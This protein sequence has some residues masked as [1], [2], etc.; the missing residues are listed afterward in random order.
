NWQ[1]GDRGIPNA[2][3][4]SVFTQT[5][6]LSFDQ[7]VLINKAEFS[8]LIRELALQAEEKLSIFRNEISVYLKKPSMARVMACIDGLTTLATNIEVTEEEP[9]LTT[10]PAQLHPLIPLIRKWAIDD[11]SNR[12]DFLENMP[13]AMLQRF[14][15]EVEPY[16]HS[17]DSDL[18]SY[19][20]KPPPEEAC[21]LGRLAECA[22][23]AKRLLEQ[24]SP[25][26]GP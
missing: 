25:M 21:A 8:S 17:I 9:D 10:L 3:G 7:R 6:D 18:D 11:D 19:G 15:E 24:K 4:Y 22:V 2:T 20:Q 13:K 14:V 16:L 23:E 26:T 1:L 5:G 12:E